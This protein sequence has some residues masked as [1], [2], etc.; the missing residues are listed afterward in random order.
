MIWKVEKRRR[1]SGGCRVGESEDTETCWLFCL[2][3]P[4]LSSGRAAEGGKG[5][6]GG[7]CVRIK[8]E[9][10]GERG[11]DGEME[12]SGRGGRPEE[13]CDGVNVKVVEWPCES[14]AAMATKTNGQRLGG[15]KGQKQL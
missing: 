9:D 7:G 14:G 15:L 5:W 12:V 3:A 1:E 2:A 4:A 10:G 11:K 6:G 8:N 13:E